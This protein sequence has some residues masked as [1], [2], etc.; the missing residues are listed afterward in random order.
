MRYLDHAATSHPKPAPVLAAI[1]E[2]FEAFGIS[3]DRG[4]S[5]QAVEV[6]QRVTAARRGLGELIGVPGERVAFHSGATESLNLALRAVL[7]P[8]DTVLT[9][10]FEHSSVVRPLRALTE[11][12]GIVTEILPPDPDFGLAPAR[13]VT[14]LE[15][16]RPRLFVFTH[17]SNVTGALFDARAFCEAARANETLSLLDV[18]QTA[19]LFDIDVGADLV[20]GSAHKG[21]HAPP[22]LGFLTARPGLELAPQKQGGT[23]SAV[24]LA[25]HP[26]TWPSAF[27]AGTPNTPAILGLAAALAWLVAEDRDQLAARALARTQDLEDR[28][29]A[30]P[31]VRLVGTPTGPRTP[32]TSFV[33]DDLDP[34]ELGAMFAAADIHVR[35]GFHCAPW[36]H[37]HLGTA[38]AGTV[39]ISP[40]PA[41]SA[42]DIAAAA[43]VVAG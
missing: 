38:A 43:A 40:G 31:G 29:A 22:G 30:I 8:G 32:V 10:A 23:G 27:E 11:E 17:A 19:G 21:L 16:L 24:A 13:V 9:T 39:R 18:S 3:A 25:D 12:R 7:R 41:V 36:I 28:L 26:T 20:A 6:N 14:A 2:W 42:D 35:T 15:R 33:H 1:N 4:D 5:H 34:A 37:G